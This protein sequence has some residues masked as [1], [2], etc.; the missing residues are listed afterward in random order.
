MKICRCLYCSGTLFLFR[1][2]PICHLD[3]LVQKQ[4]SGGSRV[5]CA[6]NF[7]LPRSVLFLWFYFTFSNNLRRGIG[8]S[9]GLKLNSKVSLTQNSCVLIHDS[10][11]SVSDIENR[12]V[13]GHFTCLFVCCFFFIFEIM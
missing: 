8:G 12:L 5:A 10:R 4:I 11:F 6:R 9:S 3:T 13:S 7:S 1:R 2:Y